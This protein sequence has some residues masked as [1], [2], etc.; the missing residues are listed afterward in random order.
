METGS[1]L[2][3]A[4]RSISGRSLD[5]A[6]YDI[7]EANLLCAVGLPGAEGLDVNAK[8]ARLDEIAADIARTIFLKSNYDR[9][10]NDPGRFYNS[11]AYFCIVC[12]VSTL[13]TKYGVKYNPKWEYITPETPTG[14]DCFGHDARDQFIHAILDG[15]GGTCASMPVFFI[16]VGR[17]IGLPLYLVKTMKHLFM[18]WDDPSGTWHF[19]GTLPSR[20]GARFNIEATGRALHVLSDKH[21]RDV[22]PHPLSEKQIEAFN[23]LES[24]TPEQELAEFLV[25]RSWCSYYNGRLEQ[26]STAAKFARLLAPTAIRKERVDWLADYA[27]ESRN[28]SELRR[29]ASCSPLAN[30]RQRSAFTALLPFQR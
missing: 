24:L 26:A 8:L 14:N 17:R 30:S 15:H 3:D 21:Y 1:L 10:L 6:K 2:S 28:V 27:E 23:L 22:W 12:M 29:L 9:F 25:M 18:R 5:P 7:A 16:A 19:N 4:F 11:R 20:T 13:K